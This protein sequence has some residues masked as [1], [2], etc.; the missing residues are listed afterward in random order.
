M[1][2]IY[3]SVTHLEALGATTVGSSSSDSSLVGLLA[4]F[5]ADFEAE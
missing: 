3:T 2:S 1:Y 4:F 5:F